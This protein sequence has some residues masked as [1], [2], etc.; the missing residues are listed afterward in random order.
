MKPNK[1]ET[2]RFFS[3]L[4]VKITNITIKSFDNMT[5]NYLHYIYVSTVTDLL[6]FPLALIYLLM[7]VPKVL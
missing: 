3:R 7:K 1:H 4:I 5:Y 2:N 6:R